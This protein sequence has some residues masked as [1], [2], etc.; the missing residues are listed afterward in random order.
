MSGRERDESEE[1]MFRD[2][3]THTKLELESSKER[4]KVESEQKDKTCLMIMLTLPLSCMASGE[5]GQT[6][7]GHDQIAEQRIQGS[8]KK[9]S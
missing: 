3:L 8:G 6:G 2:V 1:G 4:E 7:S 5:Q 9:M